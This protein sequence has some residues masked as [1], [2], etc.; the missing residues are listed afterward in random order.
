MVER[1]A[2]Y[3][4]DYVHDPRNLPE[5]ASGLGRSVKLEDGRWVAEAAFGWVV[6]AFVERNDFGVLD[7]DVTLPSGEVIRNP[8]RVIADGATRCD[9]VFTLRRQPHAGDEEFERDIAAV[10]GDLH[11]LKRVMES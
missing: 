1:P 9:V 4:Y 6:V 10:T 2:Q 5:W 11:T 7:H 8:L 3:V